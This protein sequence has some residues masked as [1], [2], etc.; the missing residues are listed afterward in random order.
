[1]AALV[2]SGPSLG[3]VLLTAFVLGDAIALYAQSQ[4]TGVSASQS[5]MDNTSKAKII[6]AIQDELAAFT[7][8][9]PTAAAAPAPAAPAA[10]PVPED[11]N[12]K[13]RA[14]IAAEL[15][16]MVAVRPAPAPA[17]APIPIPAPAPAPAPIEKNPFLAGTNPFDKP[18]GESPVEA[19]A[20]SAVNTMSK[21]DAYEK[22]GEILEAA[23]GKGNTKELVEVIKNYP[24]IVTEMWDGQSTL[25]LV[26]EAAIADAR[27]AKPSPGFL[28]RLS[29]GLAAALKPAVAAVGKAGK[30]AAEAAAKANKAVNPVEIAKRRQQESMLRSKAY[31]RV[32][33]TG[34]ATMNEWAAVVG[35]IL[36]TPYIYEDDTLEDAATKLDD[37]AEKFKS[38]ETAVKNERNA[39]ARG[40]EKAKKED[41]VTDFE[42]ARKLL[43]EAEEKAVEV[44]KATPRPMAAFN[45][46]IAMR[47]VP[48]DERKPTAEALVPVLNAFM[49]WRWNAIHFPLSF[50]PEQVV[51]AEH[52]LDGLTPGTQPIAPFFNASV[53]LRRVVNERNGSILSPEEDA[54]KAAY[55]KARQEA[56]VAAAEVQKTIDEEREKAQAAEIADRPGGQEK[57]LASVAAEAERARTVEAAALEEQVRAKEARAP[58]SRMANVVPPL[59]PNDIFE[60]PGAPTTPFT[61]PLP[62]TPAQQADL[63]GTSSQ[64][65][66]PSN[67]FETP[68]APPTTPFAPLSPSPPTGPRA[69][70][71][72]LSP[73]PP[74]P[75][76]P[77]PVPYL[78]PSPSPPTPAPYLLPATP[79]PAAAVSPGIPQFTPN[80][81]VL[82]GADAVIRDAKIRRLRIDSAKQDASLLSLKQLYDTVV[83][84]L[85]A[86]KEDVR[87]GSKES[88][89]IE[90]ATER[91]PLALAS[92]QTMVDK[93]VTVDE[94]QRFNEHIRFIVDQIEKV[95]NPTGGRRRRRHKTPKRRR[96]RKS[97]FRRH[98]KH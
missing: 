73:A 78:L 91:L 45:D 4:K 32:K 80:Q 14:V 9:I 40:L 42:D 47:D 8:K 65:L 57:Y 39:S 48:K 5:W 25:Q 59:G 96:V 38:V 11:V 23:K 74:V 88:A 97:T 50:Q 90:L 89:F 82:A 87:A 75:A 1:M 84:E 67:I 61:P 27:G 3:T 79:T 7:P 95:H 77:A 64:P 76:A 26:V 17:P 85:D 66:G 72:E 16:A 63:F 2:A 37:A 49:W 83:A 15:K 58:Q 41:A 56:D 29:S 36:R 92:Y 98:R 22:F 70:R 35:Q 52:L 24:S 86:T 46:L 68:G 53:T 18:Q 54:E 44:R 10:A 94:R 43:M 33:T 69:A 19:S 60:R 12:A 30:I 31:S 51:D 6:R 81:G 71:L 13:I 55:E 34:G 62:P 28:G 20:A 21:E 93:G